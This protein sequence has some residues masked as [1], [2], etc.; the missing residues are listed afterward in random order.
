MITDNQSKIENTNMIEE[1]LANTKTITSKD[2]SFSSWY[3]VDE[4]NLNIKYDSYLVVDYKFLD[5]FDDDGEALIGTPL[6]SIFSFQDIDDIKSEKIRLDVK[7][8]YELATAYKIKIEDINRYG[9]YY[10]EAG[11]NLFRSNTIIQSADNAF[12]AS[13]ELLDGKFNILRQENYE[14]IPSLL[15]DMMENNGVKGFSMLIYELMTMSLS[16]DVNDPSKEFRF[17]AKDK[18]K[19]EDFQMINIRDISRNTSSFSALSSENISKGILTALGQS[20]KENKDSII[21]P[22]EQIA[23]GRF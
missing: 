14:N 1:W 20:K 21:T 22:Q 13:K 9:L 8:P 5:S 18:N 2:S 4:N 15:S 17:N 16:R 3:S 19:S 10:I 7:I 23:L 12:L 11:A 6:F